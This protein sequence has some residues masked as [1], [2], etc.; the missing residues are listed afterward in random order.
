MDGQTAP[1]RHLQVLCLPAER[2]N[3][4]GDQ[5]FNPCEG[6]EIAVTAFMVAERNVEVQARGGHRRQYTT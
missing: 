5:V 6:V 4:N 3:V 1:S 2:L